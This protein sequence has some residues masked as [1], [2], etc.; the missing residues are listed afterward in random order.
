M[1][2]PTDPNWVFRRKPA[3]GF[4]GMSIG[5]EVNPSGKRGWSKTRGGMRFWGVPGTFG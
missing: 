2:I 1:R 4:E 5:A 3:G